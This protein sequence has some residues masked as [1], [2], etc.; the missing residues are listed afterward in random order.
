M[1]TWL[2]LNPHKLARDVIFALEKILTRGRS[3]GGGSG[4]VNQL[5]SSHAVSSAGSAALTLP[6]EGD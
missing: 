1:M 4:G 5:D 3:S 2:L 6:P